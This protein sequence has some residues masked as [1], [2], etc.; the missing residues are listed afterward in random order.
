MAIGYLTNEE[1]TARWPRL[2]RACQWVA[3]LSRGEAGCA[4]RDYRAGGDMRQY[5][6]GE[7]V[8]HFGGPERVIR[9][10]IATRS[11]ARASL[12]GTLLR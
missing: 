4:L 9:R 2:T 10:A 3:I 1:C 5:G 8:S 12:G 6:G 11:A 7:A